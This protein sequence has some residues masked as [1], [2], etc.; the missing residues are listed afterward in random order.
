MAWDLLSFQLLMV[1][2]FKP[3][4]DELLKNLILLQVA[5]ADSFTNLTLQIY[6]F[7]AETAV[8]CK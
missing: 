1:L 4:L 3:G 5:S 8:A 7:L 2:K 6:R